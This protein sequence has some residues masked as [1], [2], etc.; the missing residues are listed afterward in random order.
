[1]KKALKILAGALVALLLVFLVGA[2]VLPAEAR[3]ERSRV[4]AAPPEVV[5][6]EVDS[7][8]RWESWSPWLHRD[9][10]IQSTYNDVE[11]GVGAES[12]WTSESSGT[13]SQR[14]VVSEPP[15][16]IETELD[17]GEMGSARAHFTFEPVAEGT[18]V[19][20]GFVSPNEG[21][22]QKWMGLL[23]ERFVGSDY[24]V[25]LERLAAQVEG[26]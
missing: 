14:I 26:G 2:A 10:T 6:A 17:F 21:P 11:A 3:T 22:V 7:L 8:R 20:W 24:E 19:T 4:I 15:R 1:M 13:G 18:R 16:R 12:R 25:G 23:V 9:P 5:F